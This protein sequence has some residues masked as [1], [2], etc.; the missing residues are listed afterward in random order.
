MDSS[1]RLGIAGNILVLL[2]PSLSNGRNFNY[3]RQMFSL[4]TECFKNENKSLQLT[5]IPA[6]Y[7]R[8][9]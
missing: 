2:F 7:V 9:V 4:N 5:H 1:I 8:E 3:L 6:T